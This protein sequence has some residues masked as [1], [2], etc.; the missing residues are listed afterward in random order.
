MVILLRLSSYKR[1]NPVITLVCI[2]REAEEITWDSTQ[3]YCICGTQLEKVSS[4]LSKQDVFHKSISGTTQIQCIVPIIKLFEVL[5]S[6][7]P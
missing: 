2:G 7:V 3:F 6:S 4:S 5:C 1:I